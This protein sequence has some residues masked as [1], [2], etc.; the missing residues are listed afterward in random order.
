VLAAVAACSIVNTTASQVALQYG[1]GPFDSVKFVQCTGPST[2]GARD[3]N[4]TEYYAP[5]GQRD[6]SF[7]TGKGEDS[8]ALTSATKD[9]QQISVTGT[10][11]FTLNTSC[12]PWKD[13]TGRTWPGGRLQAFWELIGK[14]YDALP[15]DADADLPGGWDEMLKNYLGAAVDRASDT[16]AL[17]FGWQDLY[18]SAQATT[19]WSTQVQQDIPR[20]LNQLTLGTNLIDIDVVLLQKPGIQPQ[21]QAGLSAKQAAV[22]RQQ[23]AAVDEQA[24]K[25]F[26]GGVAGYQAYQEQQ[27]VNQAITDG[28]VKI[29]PIPQGSPVVVG[30]N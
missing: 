12:V 26:P 6:W 28:K 29:I 14:K 27:A 22:L 1:G 16:E 21:L 17:N 5:L 3:V 15:T 8:P 9:G 20:I 7:G 10:V 4:D 23:A 25:N 24:A 11:K 30:G 13:S 19:S 18:T 2:H